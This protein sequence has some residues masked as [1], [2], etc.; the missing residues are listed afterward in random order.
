MW[1]Y[2][3]FL[4]GEKKNGIVSLTTP[5]S[6]RPNDKNFLPLHANP[7]QERYAQSVKTLGLKKHKKIRNPEWRTYAYMKSA[8]HFS[9]C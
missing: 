1:N 2:R 7:K 4:L 9:S 5:K 3:G 6:F 8:L